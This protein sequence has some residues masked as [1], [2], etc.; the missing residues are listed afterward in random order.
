M[1]DKVTPIL[2]PCV[3][4]PEDWEWEDFTVEETTEMCGIVHRA[5]PDATLDGD[6]T[7]TSSI[8]DIYLAIKKGDVSGG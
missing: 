8:V 2:A 6:G 3:A 4:I 5:F 7:F 1:E